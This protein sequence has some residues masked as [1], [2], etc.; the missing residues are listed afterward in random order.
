MNDCRGCLS[1]TV[2]QGGE[3]RKENDFAVTSE[4]S[5]EAYLDPEAAKILKVAAEVEA[6]IAIVGGRGYGVAPGFL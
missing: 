4:Q 6:D 3:C 1:C 5:K 2:Y